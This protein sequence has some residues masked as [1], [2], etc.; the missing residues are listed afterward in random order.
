MAV[1]I[2]AGDAEIFCTLKYFG[3]KLTQFSV[4][5]KLE[6]EKIQ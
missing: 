6:K 1:K 5:R 4:G 2:V 3:L